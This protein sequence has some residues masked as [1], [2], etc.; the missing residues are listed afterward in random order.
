MGISPTHFNYYLDKQP[1]KGIYT[2]LN[3]DEVKLPL[4]PKESAPIAK[5]NA[6]PVPICVTNIQSN[7]ALSFSSIVKTGEYLGV[8]K[9]YLSRCIKLG[10]PCKG[11]LVKISFK[12]Q[13][14]NK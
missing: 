4:L 12:N 14:Q 10:K 11:D 6:K 7:L 9:S 1:I 8:T 13:T 5:E 3:L 2:I